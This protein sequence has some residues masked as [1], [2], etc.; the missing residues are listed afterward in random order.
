MS[1]RILFSIIVLLFAFS[2]ILICGAVEAK[3]KPILIGVPCSIGFSEGKSSVNAMELAVEE[4]N[5]KGGVSVGGIKRPFKLEILDTRDLEPGVPTSEALLTV[6]KLILQK[7][8]DVIIGGPNRSEAGLATL[9]LIA[10]YKRPWIVTAGTYTPK[11]TA[12]IGANRVKYKHCFRSH[13]NVMN[14]FSTMIPFS[15]EVKEKYGFNSFFQIVQDVT[16]ARAASG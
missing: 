16:W 13:G 12:T 1:R 9:D 14:I 4:I 3:V 8:A 15:K 2:V 7:K 10:K 11:L 6:E 5:G